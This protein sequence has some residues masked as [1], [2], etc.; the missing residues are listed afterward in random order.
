MSGG[1]KIRVEATDIGSG[2]DEALRKAKLPRR[3]GRPSHY[4]LEDAR[5][6]LLSR[7][8]KEGLRKAKP[9]FYSLIYLRPH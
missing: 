9:L 5:R 1:S 8:C 2:A 7:R 4:S 6:R 3:Y